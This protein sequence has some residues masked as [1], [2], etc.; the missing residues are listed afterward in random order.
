MKLMIVGTARLRAMAA[1]RDYNWMSS[2][3]P[4]RKHL[5]MKLG[6]GWQKKCCG[7][8]ANPSGGTIPQSVWDQVLSD[9]RFR[10]DMLTLRQ[11]LRQDRITVKVGSRQERF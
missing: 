2:L 7:R 1:D 9:R 6:S 11:K 3:R 8:S 5:T 10:T 4:V